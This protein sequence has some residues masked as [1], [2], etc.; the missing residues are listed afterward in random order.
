[1][2]ARALKSILSLPLAER[3]EIVSE[4][5]FHLCEHV[6]TL[7]GAVQT[8][9]DSEQ[10]RGA[11]ILDGAA[12][13]ETGK[14]FVLLDWARAGSS[15]QAAQKRTLSQFYDHVARGIQARL[16]DL[17]PFDFEDAAS[18]VERMRVSHFLD[19][20]TDADW[21]F[22]NEIEAEREQ[23]L[24]VD[25]VRFDDGA[26]W[27]SPEDRDSMALWAPSTVTRYVGSLRRT[28][29]FTSDGLRLAGSA[30]KNAQMQ[31]GMRWAEARRR[32]LQIAEA[33]DTAGLTDPEV[34]QDDFAVLIDRWGFPLFDLDLTRRDV[35]TSEL[36]EQRC[37]ATDRFLRGVIE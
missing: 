29:L 10:P 9:I 7:R 14:V 22:R 31:S 12:I 26:Q 33:L 36:D 15:R 25:Y 5:L 18:L 19:G 2:E 27:V 1:M 34:T 32:N 28:G 11:A 4:G 21:V 24:Y 16:A 30:W 35:P 17:R 37:A 8:L 3:F 6:E 13:E 23:A 20:P